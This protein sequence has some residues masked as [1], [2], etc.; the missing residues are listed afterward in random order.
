[1]YGYDV[2]HET[3]AEN[4][5]KS[6]RNR[7]HSHAYIFE[8]ERGVGSLE[9]ARL[10]AAAMVCTG[11]SPPC[12]TCAACIMAK[13]ETHPDI[14]FVK[15]SETKK[16]ITI[17]VIRDVAK[18]AYTKP[19]ESEK[20]VYIICEEMN[21]QAQNAFLKMLEEPPEYAVFIILSE[22]N[23]TFLNTIRSRCTIIHFPPVSA[24]KIKKQLVKEY[25]N[26]GE[27][28]DFASRFCGG[29]IEKA[30]KILEDDNFIPLREKA[31]EKL[32]TLFSKKTSD[33]YEIVD[34]LEENKDFADSIFEFWQSYV[35]DIMLIQNEARNLIVN[36]DMTDKLCQMA[37]RFE[38]YAVADA[39]EQII[40]AQKMR[41]RYVNFRALAL[42]LAFNINK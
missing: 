21:E 33:A 22:N 7:T 14:S 9:A 26:M 2:L 39:I 29:V 41:K 30:K 36:I 5:I 23:E 10:F 27:Q 15:P 32:V 35:R 8:G 31:L 24:D 20:K 40:T 28:L 1:M 17:D 4:L 16:N 6:V 19:Y 25:P 42:R 37:I 38:E 34:F 11:N 3:L 13:A 12:G 18:D